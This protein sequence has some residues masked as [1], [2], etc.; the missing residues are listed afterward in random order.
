MNGYLQFKLDGDSLLLEVAG[1]TDIATFS[2]TAIGLLL[3]VT[4]SGATTINGDLTISDATPKLVLQ[5]S[6]GGDDDFEW[7]ADGDT[8]TH[9]VTGGSSIYTV[10]SGTQV[11]TFS[12]IP[13]G[14]ASDPTTDNQLVRKAYVDALASG[15]RKVLS[16]SVNTTQVGNVGTGED[17]LMT[18][19][20]PGGT[21]SAN[22]KVLIYTGVG[23]F[24]NG[25]AGNKT[26]RFRVNGNLVYTIGP[27]TF[28]AVWRSTI[29]I[30]RTSDTTV[31][32]LVLHEH[33]AL[34]LG[35]GSTFSTFVNSVEVSDL[36]VN[37][38]TI[39]FTGENS[40]ANNDGVTQ[41]LQSVETIN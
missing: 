13:V 17:D 4:I 16:G 19:S 6:T 33:L 7:E 9:R 27:G 1:G 3:P 35:A 25:V 26:L 41:N 38:N 23:F 8:L 31:T 22:G 39:K 10:A 2:G 20:V 37:A 15:A 11:L 30:I 24:N 21:L 5:D 32:C 34:A 14:P 40:A 18:F 36:D 28:N 29:Y 12:Q